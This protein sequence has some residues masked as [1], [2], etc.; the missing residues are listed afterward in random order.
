MIDKITMLINIAWLWCCLAHILIWI[1][2]FLIKMG[3]RSV[4]N[5]QPQGH[6]HNWERDAKG[7]TVDIP[8]VEPNPE[9]VGNNPKYWPDNWFAIF[10]D[11]YTCECGEEKTE[12][13]RDLY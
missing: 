10:H 6:K 2:F 8:P 3:M 1:A 4:S 5:R 9:H 7:S 11:R 12:T 13:H